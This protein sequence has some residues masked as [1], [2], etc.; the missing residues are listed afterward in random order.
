MN[1][2]QYHKRINN[3]NSYNNYNNYN[4]YYNGYGYKKQ[5]SKNSNNN[6]IN[7][8][9]NYYNNNNELYND[10]L[11]TQQNKKKK[12][13][14]YNN[15]NNFYE[16]NN[17]EIMSKSVNEIKQNEDELMKVKINIKEN[18]FKEL[19]VHKNDNI[20]LLVKQFCEENY[21]DESLVK[22]LT[23]KIQQGLN[24]LNIV[25]NNIELTRNGVVMLEKAKKLAQHK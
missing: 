14:R 17:D 1:K 23:N 11:Y 15:N 20:Y 9:M 13:Y 10:Y 12:S 19:V 6:K 18:N 2:T 3:V 22:P 24:K 16:N 4:N 5:Y 7:N 25:K 8:S 21:M